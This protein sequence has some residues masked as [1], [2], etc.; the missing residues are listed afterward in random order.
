MNLTK[1]KL[2]MIILLKKRS[3]FVTFE[4]FWK[5]YVKKDSFYQT[6]TQIIVFLKLEYT[7]FVNYCAAEILN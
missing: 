6:E 5:I 2:E 1:Y 7:R 4:N 3:F